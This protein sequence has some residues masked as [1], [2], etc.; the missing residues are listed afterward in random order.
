VGQRVM[1]WTGHMLGALLPGSL[2]DT[3]FRGYIGVSAEVAA[4]AWEMMEELDCLPPLLKRVP[5]LTAT[6]NLWQL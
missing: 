3:Y 1:G 6:W 4:E 5:L 2:E